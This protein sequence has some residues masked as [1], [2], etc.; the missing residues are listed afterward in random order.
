MNVEPTSAAPETLRP[1]AQ[2]VNTVRFRHVLLGGLDESDV[3]KKVE[4]LQ[5]LYE[6]ALAAERVRYD[7]LLLACVKASA[8]AKRRSP[9]ESV[10]SHG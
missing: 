1:I 10:N 8:A 6:T 5:R 7:S 2:W 3:W 9:A 4:E